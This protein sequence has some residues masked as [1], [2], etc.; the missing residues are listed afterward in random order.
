MSHGT[1]GGQRSGQRLG[2]IDARLTSRLLTGGGGRRVAG[3]PEAAGGCR[4][5]GRG[6]GRGGGT[7]RGA[8]GWVESPAGRT[9]RPGQ[10]EA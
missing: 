5:A 6:G 2:A 1:A 3:E 4:A 7:V 10:A 8:R 9:G